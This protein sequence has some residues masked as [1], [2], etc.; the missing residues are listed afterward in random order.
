MSFVKKEKKTKRIH[1]FQNECSKFAR[2]A[3]LKGD[4]STSEFFARKLSDT[5]KRRELLLRSAFMKIKQFS[6]QKEG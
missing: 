6:M 2:R 3:L 4:P 5:F 1:N